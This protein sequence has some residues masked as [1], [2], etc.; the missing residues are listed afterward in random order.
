M[1]GWSSNSERRMK[2]PP[3]VVIAEAASGSSGAQ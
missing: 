2:T 1:P 3:G